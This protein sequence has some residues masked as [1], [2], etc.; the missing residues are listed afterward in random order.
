MIN[1]LIEK[2]FSG[3]TAEIDGGGIEWRSRHKGVLRRAHHCRIYLD[4]KSA[5]SLETNVNGLATSGR[6]VA[7]SQEIE[8][9]TAFHSKVTAERNSDLRNQS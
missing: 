1:V 9:G 2:I 8:T 7:S 4:G 6:Y 3:Y 5:G